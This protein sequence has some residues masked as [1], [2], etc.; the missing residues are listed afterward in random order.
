VYECEEVRGIGVGHGV[1]ESHDEEAQGNEADSEL[2]AGILWEV[3]GIGR[4]VI[5]DRHGGKDVL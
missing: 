3:G 1:E 4:V 5:N 2:C